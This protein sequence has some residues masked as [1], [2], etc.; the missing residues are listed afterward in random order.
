VT[1]LH[2]WT[3]ERRNGRPVLV[4]QFCD[5]VMS[6]QTCREIVAL[7]S[8]GVCEICGVARAETMHHRLTRKY[9]PWSPSNIVALCGDGVR[10]CHGLVTNT[11]SQY[12]DDGWLIHTWDLRAPDEIPFLHWQWG[13]VCLDNVGDYHQKGAAA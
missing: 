12:Y 10:G 1:H 8:D 7:R 5:K 4:C 6:E 3:T 9:G 13:S 11:R 2:A